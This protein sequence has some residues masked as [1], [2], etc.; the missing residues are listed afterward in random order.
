MKEILFI[1]SVFAL[2]AGWVSNSSAGKLSGKKILLVIAFNDFRDEEYLEPRKAFEKEGAKV[3]VASSS[4][5][6]AKG[7]LGAKAKVDILLKDAKAEDYDCVVF[8]GG[9][10]SPE[11]WENASAHALAKSAVEKGKVLGSIC[12]A[13][14]TLAKAGVIKGKRATGWASSKGEIV[15]GGANYT[16]VKVE[17]DGKFI[18]GSGP[19]AAKDFASALVKA[20]GEK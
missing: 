18:S 7:M 14:A 4:L 2:L 1:L 15:S 9:S 3:I 6:N 8:V 12:L 13:T 5:G 10:G 11:Y 16:G 19:E 20:L 17:V